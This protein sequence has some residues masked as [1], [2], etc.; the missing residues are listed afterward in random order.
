MKKKPKVVLFSK[1]KI[2]S[3]RINKDL[4]VNFKFFSY[5]T[6]KE[7]T[8]LVTKEPIDYLLV[9][10]KSTG[11]D[12]PTIKLLTS[13]HKI[14]VILI[15]NSVTEK[16]LKVSLDLEIKYF[17]LNKNIKTLA[18]IIISNSGSLKPKT[19]YAKPKF[20]KSEIGYSMNSDELLKI[21]STNFPKSYVA[22]IGIVYHGSTRFIYT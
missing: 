2:L 16:V 15:S 3:K 8:S 21:V 4:Q 11:K 18:E 5:S 9:D 17:V 10:F 22:I 19:G 7:L 1:D 13:L 20:K 6:I 14:P 12:I